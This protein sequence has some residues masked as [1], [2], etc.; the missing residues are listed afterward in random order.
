MAG[1]LIVVSTRGWI[2]VG[3]GPISVRCGGWNDV[4]LRVSFS[5]LRVMGILGPEARGPGREMDGLG[6]R[7]IRRG[8]SREI[9]ERTV[10]QVRRRDMGERAEDGVAAPGMLPVPFAQHRLHLLPLELLLGAAEVAGNDREFPQ[11][12]VR[13]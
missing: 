11:G 9:E 8:D 7:L 2:S 12:R 1:W 4:I 5:L 3:P 13:L 6:L 10:Q